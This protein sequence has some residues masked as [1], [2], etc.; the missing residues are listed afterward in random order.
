MML[1]YGMCDCLICAKSQ[2][3]QQA[4][5]KYRSHRVSSFFSQTAIVNVDRRLGDLKTGCRDCIKQLNGLQ[6]QKL[7]DTDVRR[8]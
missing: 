5:L 4:N 1:G 2:K 6:T 7:V 8:L 3:S